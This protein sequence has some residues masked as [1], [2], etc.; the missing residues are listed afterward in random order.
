MSFWDNNGD[1]S[2]V[3]SVEKNEYLICTLSKQRTPQQYLNLCFQAGETIAF[4]TRGKGVVHLTGFL[5]LEDD[6]SM[7]P[8]DEEDD[9]EGAYID[10][11]DDE[12]QLETQKSKADKKRK[13]EQLVKLES[14]KQKL[15]PKSESKFEEIDEE[16]E[17]SDLEEEEGEGSDEE[18]E[19]EESG[20]EEEDDDDDSEMWDDEADESD[21]EAEEE[22]VEEEEEAGTGQPQSGKK[23]QQESPQKGQ[24]TPKGQKT[25]KG[26][27]ASQSPKGQNASQTP[28]GQNA[29]QTP[30]GQNQKEK[31]GQTP[32]TPKTPGESPQKRTVQGGVQI[33]DIV[34]GSGPV[35]KTGK[36]LAMYYEGRLKSN[37][38]MFDSS[39]SGPPFK[40]RLGANEVIKGWDVGIQGMKVGG[41]R[42]IIIPPH[43]G[44][45]A[46]GAAPAIPPNS[47][48]CFEVE[49]KSVS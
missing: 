23:K 26:Q 17:D 15:A 10:D 37:S 29:S 34:V 16:E 9:E 39:L 13:L 40:F 3:V 5:A 18:G 14:K 44:Y 25:P 22:E 41:K 6:F 36:N 43:M 30:K 24:Q 35:A 12:E 20:E 42:K 32:K 19:E 48:L 21:D 28:K 11:E 27:N 46:K 4:M 8:S 38:K 31:P 49:L 45:G 1:V 2:V 33:E 47:T 7:M